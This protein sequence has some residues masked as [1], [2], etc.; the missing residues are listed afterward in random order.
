M[1]IHL[2]N[3][4]RALSL[5][6]PPLRRLARAL[7]A[8]AFPADPPFAE[9]TIL[10]TD[11]AAMPDYKAGCFGVRQQTDVVA[12]AY[13]AMPGMSAATAE[14][15]INAERARQEGARRAG[16]AA[17]ELAL[18]LAHGMDHLAGATDDTPARRQAMRRR[19]NTWLEATADLWSAIVRP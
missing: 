2:L 7:A 15:V 16:G 11:D 14:L 3:Q 18:Y 4:Q 12:Q 6:L 10:L 13:A 8:W 19:E 5:N 17:R 1:K 9:L